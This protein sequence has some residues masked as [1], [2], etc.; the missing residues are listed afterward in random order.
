MQ[1]LTT[2]VQKPFLFWADIHFFRTNSRVD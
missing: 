1:F 2:R